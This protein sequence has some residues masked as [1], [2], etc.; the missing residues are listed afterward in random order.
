MQSRA[1]LEGDVL[2]H[3]GFAPPRRVIGPLFR[4]IQPIGLSCLPIQAYPA[5]SPCQSARPILEPSDGL[6]GDTPPGLRVVRDREAKER[7]LPR[8]GDGTLL[9]VDLQLETP[10]DEAGQILHDPVACLLAA[11]I[12]VAVIRVSHETVATVLKFAIQFVQHEI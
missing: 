9:R 5:M 10:L 7:S 4:Q 12:D 1:W 8:P 6:V 2:G 3:A 11:D